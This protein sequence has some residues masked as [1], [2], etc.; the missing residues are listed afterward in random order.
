MSDILLYAESEYRF[1]AMWAWD[2]PKAAG[3]GFGF[4]EDAVKCTVKEELNGVFELEMTYPVKG[5]RY[6]ELKVGRILYCKPDP[7]DFPQPF[8]IYSV[9]KSR[10]GYLS[11]RARHLAYDIEGAVVSAFKVSG[12][13]GSYTPTNNP[14]EVIENLVNLS[15]PVGFVKRYTDGADQTDYIR[16]RVPKPTKLTFFLSQSINNLGG[17]TDELSVDAPTSVK[18]VLSDGDSS[19]IGTYGGELLFDGIDIS[20]VPFRG[21]DRGIR[22]EYGKNLTDISQETSTEEFYTALLPYAET[23]TESQGDHDEYPSVG[24]AL[25]YAT[26]SNDIS[27]RIVRPP[28]YLWLFVA[29]QQYEDP[30]M[31]ETVSK[32]QAKYASNLFPEGYH[33][34]YPGLVFTYSDK[35]L[36][37]DGVYYMHYAQDD[38]FVYERIGEVHAVINR[39]NWM[40]LG[41]EAMIEGFCVSV[42]RFIEAA[43]PVS[44]ESVFPYERI[45]PVDLGEYLNTDMPS[46]SDVHDKAIEYL[47]IHHI[48]EPK[49]SL[50]TSFT[51]LAKMTD[52]KSVAELEKIV[53]G[54]VVTVMF[55]ELGVSSAA[56][57]VSTEYD[58]LTD[59]YTSLTIGERRETISD[60]LIKDQKQNN[61]DI[62]GLREQTTAN[63]VSIQNYGYQIGTK[64]SGTE[65]TALQTVVNAKAN[66]SD[67]SALQT[68]L[69]GKASASDLAALSA[70]VSALAAAVAAIGSGGG[71]STGGDTGGGTEGGDTGGGGEGGNE[72]GGDSTTPYDYLNDHSGG[73]DGDIVSQWME[74]NPIQPGETNEEYWQRF[75][76]DYPEY[77]D[78]GEGG[79]PDPHTG[80]TSSDFE[81]YL[82]QNADDPNEYL[83]DE[84]MQNNPPIEGE[85]LEDYLD[86]YNQWNY[87]NQ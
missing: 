32:L 75:L 2:T 54:D 18:S 57:V 77:G 60:K 71:G 48:L 39:E 4:V 20:V 33:Y 34:N 55:P 17:K 67:L 50:T 74:N 41:F 79:D 56:R 87:D 31:S 83:I 16:G 38:S 13:T 29:P 68:A 26:N 86:R 76:A 23:K 65:L 6:S 49:F 81:N 63:T 61:R 37:G 14:D 21:E 78:N 25:V 47:K 22:I 24:R 30:G 8:R 62:D 59:V 72:G 28:L 19:M 36:I 45:L 85:S 9:K 11:I 1:G 3:L 35:P 64:A 58:V 10:N 43:E 53:L 42:T 7:Y 51:D 69:N 44:V 66:A 80:Y 52:Y 12:P 82:N 40:T 5:A 73:N 15:L 27:D 46:W 84:F 70:E